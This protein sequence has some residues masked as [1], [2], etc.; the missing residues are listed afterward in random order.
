MLCNS[1]QVDIIGVNVSIEQIEPTP[2]SEILFIWSRAVTERRR[3]IVQSCTGKNPSG[4][5]CDRCRA[6]YP[7]IDR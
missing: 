5:A 3:S 1:S 2:L 4:R 7:L 6:P